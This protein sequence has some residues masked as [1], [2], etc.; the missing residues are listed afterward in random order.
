M[1][2]NNEGL[3]KRL[4]FLRK[5]KGVTQKQLADSLGVSLP[6]IVNYENAQR[7]PSWAVLT[8]LAQYFN[9]DGFIFYT[10]NESAGRKTKIF[11]N[12][13]TAKN[14]LYT[15]NHLILD[16]EKFIFEIIEIKK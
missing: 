8:L 6:A 5:E 1:M 10:D 3:V 16:A 9:A 11:E 7:T 12:L 4:K 15:L 14:I 13:K 2:E